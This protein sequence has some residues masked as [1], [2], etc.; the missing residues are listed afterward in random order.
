MNLS[1]LHIHPTAI[2]ESG[3]KLAAG[4]KVGAYAYIGS[5]VTLG[6]N[7]VVH[8]HATVEGWVEMG[9]GNQIYPYALIGGKT[10]DLKYSG[11]RSGLRIGNHNEFREY[12]SV[13]PATGDG[14]FTIIGNHNHLLAYSHVAHDCILGDH[15][16]MSGQN[17]LAG[18]ITVGDHAVIAWGVGVHQFCRVGCYAM[19]GAMSRNSK[20]IPPYMITEGVPAETRAVN[21]VNMERNGFTHEQILRVGRIFR[22]FYRD[23]RNR[24]Q[25]LEI[26]RSTP[27]LIE[28]T[29][30]RTIADFFASTQRGVA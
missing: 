16:V 15:I 13:H 1:E 24:S 20:D 7:C 27:E 10:H 17:A 23:G 9:E 5:E 14:D 6:E 22:L 3:A 30:G 11:G 21:K 12:V 28:S 2:I 26:L 25:A 4:V 8:H 18:H 29:E 19:A